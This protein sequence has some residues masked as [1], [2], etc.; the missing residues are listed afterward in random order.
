VTSEFDECFDYR[1]K[2]EHLL[3]GEVG[4]LAKSSK[5]WWL[6]SIILD[7]DQDGNSKLA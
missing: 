2:E 3:T 5:S 7:R 1:R 6:T 4:I